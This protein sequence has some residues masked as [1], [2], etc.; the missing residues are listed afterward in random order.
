MKRN[1]IVLGVTLLLLAIFAWAGWANW[2]YRKQAA[3]HRAD[4]ATLKAALASAANP[5]EAYT[6]SP[7]LGKQ[8]PSFTLQDL[9]GKQISL[10]DYRGKALL[11]NFWATWCGPCK[12]ETPWLVDLQ[13]QYAPQG[14]E[15]L[16]VDT[17]DDEVT[18][19]DKSAWAKDKTAVAHFAQQEHMPYPVLLG[20]DSISHAYGDFDAMP[21][22]FFVNRS[23]KIIAAQM[24]ITSEDDMAL[25]IR[26]A[27]SQ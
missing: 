6:Q 22:S 14:F 20:G 24:G 18:P 26:Q 23:G 27:L 9:T 19:A 5:E 16:G 1:T 7:L 17:E 3:Q 13:K 25:K 4:A 2:E 8:A 10:A 21:T 11:I 15:I 12:L